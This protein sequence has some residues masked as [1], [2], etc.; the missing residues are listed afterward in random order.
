MHL[1]LKNHVNEL[2]NDLGYEDIPESRLFEFFSNYCVV[3][4][5]FLGRFD[6]K[7]V[8]TDGD[9]ASLDGVA[10]IVDGDLILTVDD[11]LEAFKTHKTSLA[12]DVVFCQSKSGEKFKKEEISNFKLGLEDYLSLDPKL[13]NGFLTILKK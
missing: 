8:T 11:A 9:D 1:I 6:P 10:I 13:P 7:D 12:V 5:H 3:S 2:A 4:K